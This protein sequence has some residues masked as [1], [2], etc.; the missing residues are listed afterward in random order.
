[1]TVQATV[2]PFA[3]PVEFAVDTT[4]D[5]FDLSQMNGYLGVQTGVKLTPGSFSTRM[6]LRAEKGRLTGWVDPRLEG[7]EL[8]SASE[9]LGSKLKA[10]LGKVTLTLSSPADGTKPSGKI[11]VADDL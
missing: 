5:H 1:M 6:K 4:V 11:A 9:G 3:T 7:T 2:A 10:L 8:E